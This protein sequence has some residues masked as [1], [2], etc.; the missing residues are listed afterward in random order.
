M[1]VSQT[2]PSSDEN[3]FVVV[4]DKGEYE[5][6]NVLFAIGAMDHP[7]HL[8]VKGEDLPKVHDTFRETY[9]WVK[10]HAL[11]VGGGNSAGEAAF[12]A[13]RSSCSR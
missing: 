7:R 4:T 8:N 9:P 5:A 1:S 3:A 11:I 6:K 12:M 13:R 10:K 2:T